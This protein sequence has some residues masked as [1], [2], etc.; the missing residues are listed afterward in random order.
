MANPA[1]ATQMAKIANPNRCR[2]LS[3][4]KAMIIEK[5]KAT[6]QGGTL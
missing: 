4:I 1:I 3:E 2:V 5:P 6:T